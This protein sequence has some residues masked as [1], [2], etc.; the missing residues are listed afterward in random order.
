[1]QKSKILLFNHTLS[2]GGGEK[3]TVGLAKLFIEQGF[4]VDVMISTGIEEEFYDNELLK[5]GAKVI[6]INYLGRRSFL[7]P[8]FL[9]LFFKF[10][11]MPNPYSAYVV[12]NVINYYT[13][14]KLIGSSAKV[15]IWHIG[16]AVQYLDGKIGVPKTWFQRKNIKLWLI[17]KYQKTELE[18]EFGELHCEIHYSKLFMDS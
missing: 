14:S 18:Q 12:V 11:L 2:I 1:M 10:R 15:N 9:K 6:R 3:H 7:N 13:F 17:N 8:N 16:N 4:D 5:I